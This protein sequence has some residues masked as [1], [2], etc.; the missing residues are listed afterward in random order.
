MGVILQQM[1]APLQ[2]RHNFLE[3][4]LFYC[5]LQSFKYQRHSNSC[6][7]PSPWDRRY[8][9][10]FQPKQWD[11]KVQSVKHPNSLSKHKWSWE[12]DRGVIRLLSRY[13][14]RP[15]TE[16]TRWKKEIEHGRAMDPSALDA[17]KEQLS[18]RYLFNSQFIGS[19]RLGYRFKREGPWKDRK[20]TKKTE[21]SLKQ[22][23]TF[24]GTGNTRTGRIRNDH[25][26]S[27]GRVHVLKQQWF[28]KAESIF[29]ESRQLG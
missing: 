13:L 16:V 8:C 21:F 14:F 22:M 12:V 27:L 7:I 6:H 29:T 9:S 28:C 25:S 26:T 15:I 4:V 19:H 24:R 2:Q 5:K 1:A 11:P 10:F 23:A 20:W 18:S 3:F 17:K